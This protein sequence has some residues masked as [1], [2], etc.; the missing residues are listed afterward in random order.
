MLTRA[1][2]TAAQGGGVYPDNRREF[3]VFGNSLASQA[4]GTIESGTTTT[5]AETASGGTS[6]TV[7][8]SASFSTSNKLAVAL[9]TGEVFKTT[10]AAVPDGTH[11]TLADELPGLVRS[12]AYV[13][14]YATPEPINIRQRYGMVAAALEQ[15]NLPVN[16]IQSYSWG[17]GLGADMMGD[18]A[19]WLA[20][21][22][23]WG[24]YLH[25]FENDIVGGAS[26]STLQD[27]ADEAAG[28][29]VAVG[30][31][32]FMATPVPSNSYTAGAMVGI[33]DDLR[34]YILAMPGTFPT[35]VPINV[36]DAWVDE[37]APTLRK[38]LTSVSTDGIHPKAEKWEYVGTVIA[39]QIASALPA[40]LTLGEISN[41][42]VNA[43]A[44]LT[45]TGGSVGGAGS[46][47]GSMADGWTVTADA[48]VAG[49][50]SRSGDGYQRIEF[51][52]AG[53]S[54]ISTTR[55]R[56]SRVISITED[57]A[58]TMLRALTRIKINALT[59]FSITYNELTFSTGEIY[60]GRQD[61]G[62]ANDAALTGLTLHFE[63][64][65]LVIPA[66]ATS[67]TLTQYFR[68]LTLTTPSGVA[69]DV[70][71]LAM[72][73]IPGW[74]PVTGIVG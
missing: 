30:A 68:P 19:V 29:C 6:L 69:A 52:V 59:N 23:P 39:P 20:A 41:L 55:L 71:I 28:L 65:P 73:A 17:G 37:T 8:S 9:Y 34:D 21:T 67:V 45:G 31:K 26:L 27:L 40:A 32:P 18:L 1:G 16:L 4:S 61:G 47:T 12:G 24:V 7:S 72:G 43:N 10:V 36:S 58:G 44:L 15:S 35:L 2:I 66:G 57:M 49:T 70:E 50:L 25:L 56:V 60:A 63:S 5:S 54:N 53:A 42:A 22:R 3:L 51:A 33:V 62:S 48:G 74:Q 38:P 64:P 13:Q 11:I 46:M 14:K